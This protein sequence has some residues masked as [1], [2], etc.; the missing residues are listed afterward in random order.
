[1]GKGFVC[2]RAALRSAALCGLVLGL[3]AGSAAAQGTTT[4][5]TGDGRAD[6]A[7]VTGGSGYYIYWV[8]DSNSS[9]YFPKIWA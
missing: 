6:F 7:V 1:M 8:A 2:L 9:D 4:D 5:Y 3:S